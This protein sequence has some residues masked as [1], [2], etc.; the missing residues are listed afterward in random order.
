MMHLTRS[1]CTLIR[2][3]QFRP[4]NR[5]SVFF[6]LVELF[7]ERHKN[8]WCE[9]FTAYRGKQTLYFIRAQK[10]TKF[11]K[12]SSHDLFLHEKLKVFGF[13]FVIYGHGHGLVLINEN[14]RGKQRQRAQCRVRCCWIQ[15]RIRSTI[16]ILMVNLYVNVINPCC[17]GKNN[18]FSLSLLNT[19]EALRFSFLLI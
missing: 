3:H 14:N 8:G 15:H 1:E 6:V 17:H 2:S 19:G 12:C 7:P 18:P 11:S 5:V 9:T 16:S 13:G 10:K 4:R